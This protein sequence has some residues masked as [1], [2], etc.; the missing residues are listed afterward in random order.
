MDVGLL[1]D[2]LGAMLGRKVTNKKN[3]GSE[4]LTFEKYA[5]LSM[6]AGQI[7]E[8][9][10]TS[11]NVID[12]KYYSYNEKGKNQEEYDIEKEYEKHKNCVLTTLFIEQST[13]KKIKILCCPQ[14]TTELLKYKIMKLEGISW[15]Q[16]K[17]LYSGKNM[18]NT[19]KIWEYGIKTNST[20]N[21][22]V[23]EDGILLYVK[24]LT[25][26]T[27]EINISISQTVFDLKCLIQDEEG[28]PPDQ[29]RIVF[30]GK[31]LEDEKTIESYN[32]KM[33][34]TTLHL[35]LRLRGGGPEE[36]HLP[37]GLFDPQYDYD[38]T[39]IDDKNK[40]FVRGG[41]DYKRPCGWKRYALKVSDKY[42]KDTQWLGHKGISNNDKE[43]AV[44]YHGTKICNAKAIIL[45]G[46][47]I[48]NRNKFGEGI[49]CT[50]NAKTAEQYSEV[51]TSPITNKKY[52]IIFQNRVKPSAIVRCKDKG[53]PDDYWYVKDGKDIRPYGF[54]IKEIK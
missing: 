42:E 3:P 18:S 36:Y 20:L 44:S 24:T 50:P 45:D 48:G 21:L 53:G 51:F 13:G 16:Q 41:L 25:G 9:W 17:L 8:K 54:C 19:K 38:F 43:W 29:Q 35:V 11:S 40:K 30:A 47:K 4:E 49:Y 14:E 31:Q 46:F 28:I 12:D 2:A 7:P 15:Y 32:I 39:K 22:K 10:N 1:Y 34:E 5:N 26:K 6:S 23:I 27:I 37:D 33:S 52:K